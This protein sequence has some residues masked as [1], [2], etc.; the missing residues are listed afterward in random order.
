MEYPVIDQHDRDGDIIG[1]AATAG[2][3]QQM[4]RDLYLQA[5]PDAD[6]LARFDRHNMVNL[7]SAD[8]QKFSNIDDNEIVSGYWAHG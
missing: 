5:D 8:T 4:L 3:A 7:Y 6:E 1:F 2:E